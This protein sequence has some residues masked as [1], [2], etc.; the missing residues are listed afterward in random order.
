M[1]D[2]IVVGVVDNLEA[3]AFKECTM[4]FPARIAN[5][6]LGVRD[7]LLEEVCADFERACAT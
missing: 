7:K 6:D 3:C 4:V 1:R 2:C 5:R